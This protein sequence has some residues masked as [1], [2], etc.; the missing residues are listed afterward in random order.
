[1]A[2][3]IITIFEFFLNILDS[4]IIEPTIPDGVGTVYIVSDNNTGSYYIQFVGICSETGSTYNIIQQQINGVT[5]VKPIINLQTTSTSPMPTISVSDFTMNLAYDPDNVFSITVIPTNGIPADECHLVSNNTVMK[6]ENFTL[7]FNS[8]TITSIAALFRA[9]T[10][11]LTPF[12][13]YLPSDSSP[14]H[15]VASPLYVC[16]DYSSDFNVGLYTIDPTFISDIMNAYNQLVGSLKA[17][18][19]LGGSAPPISDIS[20]SGQVFQVGTTPISVLEQIH[21]F[22]LRCELSEVG[23]PPVTSYIWRKDG[24]LIV[25]NN[26]KY[27]IEGDKLTIKNTEESDQGSYRCFVGNS[28]GSDQ[29]MTS[30]DI[31]QEPEATSPPSPTTPPPPQPRW[32]PQPF[33]RVSYMYHLL[34]NC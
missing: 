9:D 28:V 13:G 34:L 18:Q 32:V 27:S 10:I 22:S 33:T 21:K 16:I 26:V 14:P 2:K 23:N 1:M 29:A 6:Y 24:Q 5:S 19:I 11:R 3:M 20:T 15:T 30:L 12:I 7:T 8:M 17:P 4:A 31:T 25:D